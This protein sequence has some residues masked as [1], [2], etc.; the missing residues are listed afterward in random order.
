MEWKKAQIIR[1][2]LGWGPWRKGYV[3]MNVKI[4]AKCRTQNPM[5]RQTC[6]KCGSSLEGIKEV[7]RGH[8][9]QMYLLTVILLALAIVILIV[10]KTTLNYITIGIAGFISAVLA[11]L[12]YWVF[13]RKSR[14]K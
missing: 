11:Y 9:W 8:P 7:R 4:C 6:R 14:K 3:G 1:W 10:I 5:D 2:T 13:S 12:L